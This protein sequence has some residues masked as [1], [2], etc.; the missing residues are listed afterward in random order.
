MI[1]SLVMGFLA[2]LIFN[3]ASSMRRSYQDDMDRYV[4]RRGLRSAPARQ[5]TTR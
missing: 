3:S 4:A 5:S 2:D 1:V